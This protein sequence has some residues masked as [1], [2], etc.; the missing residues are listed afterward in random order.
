MSL[1]GFLSGYKWSELLLI[2][3]LAIIVLLVYFLGP[4]WLVAL[5]FLALGVA[6]I[7]SVVLVKKGIKKPETTKPFRTLA[8]YALVSTGFIGYGLDGLF[9]A[10]EWHPESRTPFYWV[11]STLIVIMYICLFVGLVIE[12]RAFLKRK[13]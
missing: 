3:L 9:T 5:V 13:R 11:T 1:S 10:L 2:V 8:G 6:G 12:W 4:P 7:I